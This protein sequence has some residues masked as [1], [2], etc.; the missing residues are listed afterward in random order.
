MRKAIWT[1]STAGDAKDQVLSELPW[2][3]TGRA[4]FQMV[5]A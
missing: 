2:M 5:W 1:R 3:M 4:L